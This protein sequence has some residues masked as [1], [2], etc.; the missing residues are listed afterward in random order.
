MFA[1]FSLTP[2]PGKRD[3]YRF[4]ELFETKK[5]AEFVLRALEKVNID[6]NLYKIVEWKPKKTKR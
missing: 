4:V 1:I 6:F 2:L 5:D 3:D